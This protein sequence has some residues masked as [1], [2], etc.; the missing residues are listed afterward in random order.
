MLEVEAGSRRVT[1]RCNC[2]V[3]QE[4]EKGLQECSNWPIG[5][6]ILSVPGKWR[7]TN[8]SKKNK[9]VF[10]LDDHA[11]TRSSPSETSNEVSNIGTDYPLILSTSPKHSIVLRLYGA[12][13]PFVAIFKDIYLYFQGSCCIKTKSGQTDFLGIK[14]PTR[15]YF[16]PHALSRNDGFHHK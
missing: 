12:P 10:M 5:I 15:M 8:D 1:K 14:C 7:S 13:E 2:S 9:R 16:V 6:I 11:A 4:R 3:I